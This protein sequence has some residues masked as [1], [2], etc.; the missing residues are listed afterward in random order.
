MS[1]FTGIPTNL[2]VPLFYA[3]FDP[4]RAG[5]S[6]AVRRALIIGPATTSDAS[7]LSY[8]ASVAQAAQTY[9]AG[10]PLAHMIAAFRRNEPFN[11]VWALNFPDAGG[12]AAATGSIGFSGAASAAGTHAFYIAGQYVPV[13]VAS[14]DSAAT[15]ATNCAAAINAYLDQTAGTPLLLP[16]TASAST[17]TVTLTA[18]A[19]GTIGNAI[20]ITLNHR[21]TQG[22]EYNVPGTTV[23]ITAMASGATDPNL[24]TLATSLG[25][26]EFEWIITPWATTTLL[27]PLTALMS[28]V[29]GR[30]AYDQALYGHV[31]AAARDSASNLLTL[32]GALNDP[33]LSV[34][35]VETGSPTPA[36][37]WAAATAGRVLGRLRDEPGR[38]TQ[39]LAI[40]GVLSA[41]PAG[42]FSLTNRNSLLTAGIAC[43]VA[44]NDNIARIARMVTT[45][46]TNAYGQVDP[47]MRDTETMCQS[48]A[49]INRLKSVITT[50][51]PD[52]RLAD[53]GTLAGPGIAIVT[54]RVIRNRLI[55]EHEAMEVLG[56]VEN[57]A[58]FARNLVVT[59]S[60]DDA[61]RVDVLLPA[62]YTSGLRIF[63]VL[64]QFR[65]RSAA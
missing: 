16:V 23:S 45:Y 10:S 20:P 38:P 3:R 15:Q 51:Y 56:W 61:S 8:V 52:Y 47:S 26:N 13:G 7:T 29:G 25:S 43:A 14:G 31:F 4:S 28:D 55:A 40:E 21:G 46:K 22:G 11:E 41:Q 63:A 36:Y 30:W 44:G 50:E 54:P 65:L 5:V 24:A 6:G 33:H 48:I 32:G 1:G 9:G 19:K 53:D 37:V 60:T 34:L 57:T 39:S 59:R 27:A 58:V 18:R 2:L 12:A 49:L 64:N 17:S 62:N 42:R 35:G